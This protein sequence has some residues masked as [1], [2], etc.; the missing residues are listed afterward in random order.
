DAILGNAE[1]PGFHTVIN[2]DAHDVGMDEA[3]ALFS[4]AQ[5]PVFVPAG[6]M[7]VRVNQEPV[8]VGQMRN[9]T[10]AARNGR[11][12]SQPRRLSARRR[13]RHSSEPLAPS[14]E[15]GAGRAAPL[16]G[17]R[18]SVVVIDRLLRR[19]GDHIGLG[20]ASRSSIRA[21]K[22]FQPSG[23]SGGRAP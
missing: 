14:A 18:P 7:P 23:G 10:K 20:L 19:A 17:A 11:Q 21:P 16:G 22:A 2:Q 6:L 5:E 13:R 3:V 9:S 15:V 8:D 4:M 12:Y 1:N